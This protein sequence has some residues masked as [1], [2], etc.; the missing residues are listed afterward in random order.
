MLNSSGWKQI[1]S[2]YSAHSPLFVPEFG[3]FHHPAPLFSKEHHKFYFLHCQQIL[4][5]I[6]EI[7]TGK[8]LPFI[9]RSQTK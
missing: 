3:H 7:F 5:I 4:P 1:L 2:T 6:H 8:N 9:K